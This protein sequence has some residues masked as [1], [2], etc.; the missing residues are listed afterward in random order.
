MRFTILGLLQLL[1]LL[2]LTS[3]VNA[4]TV[5]YGS[6]SSSNVDFENILATYTPTANH[7][8]EPY[9]DPSAFNDTLIF[10]ADEF[11]VQAMNS[12]IDFQAGRVSLTITADD[13][14]FMDSIDVSAF[15]SLF[16]FG[17]GSSSAAQIVGFVEIGNQTYTNNFFTS[18]SGNQNG[19][20]AD[21]FTINFAPSNQITVILQ[22]QLF[23][24]AGP[25]EVSYIDFSSIIIGV[26]S[27]PSAIPEPNTAAI[28]FAGTA[29]LTYVRK[30]R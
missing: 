10:P 29:A 1:V 12:G 25:N 2:A 5:P 6:K 20:W 24:V 30:R 18:F 26:N 7:P 4:D 3:N 11:R 9:G 19:S 23:S 17:S 8:F 13:G 27:F 22:S 28:L 15:G 16:M 21:N 14:M